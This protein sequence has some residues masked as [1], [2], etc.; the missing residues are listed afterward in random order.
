MSYAADHL[1]WQQRL[2]KE[3]SAA[4]YPTFKALIS[5]DSGRLPVKGVAKMYAQDN[6]PSDPNA[7]GNYAFKKVLKNLVTSK[8]GA[9]KYSA[10]KEEDN[11]NRF[12]KILGDS[13][14]QTTNKNAFSPTAKHSQ[15]LIHLRKSL[16]SP[17]RKEVHKLLLKMSSDNPYASPRFPKAK[18]FFE[19]AYVAKSK[20]GTVSQASSRLGKFERQNVKETAPQSSSVKSPEPKKLPPLEKKKRF[21]EEVDDLVSVRSKSKKGF[22]SKFSLMKHTNLQADLSDNQSL[23]HRN[24]NLK[25]MNHKTNDNVET[26]SFKNMLLQTV[27]LMSDKE[28]EIMQQA[29]Q[30]AK[31]IVHSDDPHFQE[32]NDGGAVD[33]NQADDSQGISL[34]S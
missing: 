29:I 6:S 26:D 2:V 24:P 15:S 14:Y 22:K 16:K 34:I 9:T 11:I 21:N 25:G 31:Q 7:A 23:T 17:E 27:E 10:K 1:A 18:P 19:Q 8:L 12:E 28:M 20:L 13:T 33:K 3:N 32:G 4:I 30:G 5:Q